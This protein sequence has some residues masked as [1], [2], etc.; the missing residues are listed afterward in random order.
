MAI[1]DTVIN[2]ISLTV[3]ELNYLL[4]GLAELPFKVAQPIIIKLQ[5]QAQ[6][7]L[8]ESAPKL[9]K[10]DLIPENGTPPASRDGL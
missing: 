3:N 10:P 9:E 2:N 4:Q 8:Q 7:Q 6:A 5:T 1:E